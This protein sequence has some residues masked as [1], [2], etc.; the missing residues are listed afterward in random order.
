MIHDS[1]SRALTAELE[2]LVANL[3]ADS[4]LP[5]TRELQKRFQVSSLTVQ[6]ALTSLSSRGLLVTRPGRGTFTAARGRPAAGGADV[7]W[8]TLALGSRPALTDDL[9]DLM[10]PEPPGLLPLA[11]GFLDESLQPR[12]LLA[13]AAS[14]AARRPHGWNRPAPGGLAEL[15]GLFAGEVSRETH[16]DDVVVTPG[17]QAA[18]V[19]IFRHLG[20]PGEALVVESP[21]YVGALAAARAAGMTAVPVPTDRH[22]VLPDALED[23]LARTR[24]RLVYLQPRHANPTGA[25]LSID[26]RG[27]VLEAVH[28]ARAFVIEDDWVRDLDLEGPTPPPLAALDPDGHVVYVRSLTK[29]VAAG[30]RVAGMVARGPALT[31]LRRGRVSD[32]LFVAPVLQQTALDVL[33]APGWPRHLGAVR[34]ALRERRDALLG[35]I[36]ADLPGCAV[37]LP[38]AGG[39]HLWLRLPEGLDDR[40]VVLAARRRGVAVSAGGA[41]FP[42]EPPAPHLRLSFAGA[43]PAALRAA[44][45]LL[46]EVLRAS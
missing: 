33:T 37:H 24:A 29:P 5:S 22:G 38:P 7:A 13:A 19:A 14:R 1:G 36:R 35:G 9:E 34:R 2:R 43:G 6:R 42:G 20:A 15:R 39:V 26:R 40:E 25:V 31:R 41:Y 30:L 32:D 44:I 27:A 23:A 28:R 17:G 11:S 12:G 18:L 4:P 16:A 8:Q 45:G 46:A 3:P 21:T 10:T